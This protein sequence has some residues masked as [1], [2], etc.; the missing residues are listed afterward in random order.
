MFFWLENAYLCQFF[1][2]FGE[3]LTNKV[4]KT[5]LLFGLRSDFISR[6]VYARLQVD[7]Q[8]LRFVDPG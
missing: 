4:G 5:D 8:L 3:T 2:W 7:V 1:V 6:S